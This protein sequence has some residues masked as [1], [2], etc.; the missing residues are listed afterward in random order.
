MAVPL[1]YLRFARGIGLPKMRSC[2]AVPRS[3]A[4]M[5]HLWGTLGTLHLLRMQCTDA[6]LERAGKVSLGRLRFGVDAF[7]GIETHRHRFQRPR[8]TTAIR[9]YRPAPGRYAALLVG[10]KRAARTYSRSKKRNPPARLRS[11]FA[12]CLRAFAHH[13]HPIGERALRPSPP[14]PTRP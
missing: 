13:R 7:S 9:G 6:A 12:Y 2:A 8:R 1:R 4:C 11:C 3:A 10:G 5:P 14:R